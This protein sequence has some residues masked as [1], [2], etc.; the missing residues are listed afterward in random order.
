MTFLAVPSALTQQAQSVL[1]PLCALSL[2]GRD[3]HARPCC[4]DA[5]GPAAFVLG[6]GRAPRDAALL[7]S[8]AVAALVVVGGTLVARVIEN[9]ASATLARRV[10]IGHLDIR[11]G[12][13]LRI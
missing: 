6:V 7:T 4:F 8:A 1:M 11:W 3:R 9:R 13:P 10:T 5:C 12:H 2:G